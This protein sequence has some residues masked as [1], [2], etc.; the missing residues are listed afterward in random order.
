MA[1]VFRFLEATGSKPAALFTGKVTRSSIMSSELIYNRSLPC[2]VTGT[3]RVLCRF[4]GRS[5][6][7][8]CI[9]C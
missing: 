2:G 9:V 3:R 5:I 7:V 4:V 8:E 1:A 6:G